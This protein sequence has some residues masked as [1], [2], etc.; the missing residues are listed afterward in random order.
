MTERGPPVDQTTLPRQ[1]ETFHTSSPP[2]ESRPGSL[3]LLM[4]GNAWG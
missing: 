2:Y 4:L 3:M 1:A